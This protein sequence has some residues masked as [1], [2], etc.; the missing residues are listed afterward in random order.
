MPARFLVVD[1]D[2]DDVELIDGLLMDGGYV[3]LLASNAEEALRVAI[4]QHPDMVLLDL[5]LPRI[6]GYE[7]AAR[8]KDEP[9]LEQTRIVAVTGAGDESERVM[10]AGFDG[11]ISKWVDPA[12][13]VGQVENLLAQ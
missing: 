11:F 7:I 3:A 4:M 12:A 8:I 9:R 13:F 10:A 1:D 5:R 6:D 2:Q